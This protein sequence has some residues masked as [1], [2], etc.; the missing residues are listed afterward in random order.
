VASEGIEAALL[1]LFWPRY[2]G[3][4]HAQRVGQTPFQTV[5]L[6]LS[7]KFSLGCG[8]SQR[9]EGYVVLLLPALPYEGVK[10]L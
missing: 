6:P 10:F 3:Q 7:K 8:A 5:S 9:K 2:N 1:G 4:I